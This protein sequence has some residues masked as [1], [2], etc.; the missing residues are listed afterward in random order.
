M[1]RHNGLVFNNVETCCDR[2][3]AVK[4]CDKSQNVIMTIIGVYMPSFQG[5]IINREI[6]IESL[7]ALQGVIDSVEGKYIIM[8]DLNVQ[9]PIQQKLTP[10]WYKCRP[11]TTH[12]KLVYD[13]ASDN[14]LTAATLSFPH[15][16]NFTWHRNEKKSF[17]DH[18]MASEEM[19]P[20]VT[21][22][23]VLEAHPDNVSD[24]LPVTCQVNVEMSIYGKTHQNSD[25]KHVKPRWA[26]SDF[27]TRYQRSLKD[28]L[29]NERITDIDSLS[30][31]EQAQVEITRIDKMVSGHML[32]ATQDGLR[33]AQTMGVRRN[34]LSRMWD[35][36]CQKAKERRDFWFH[37]FKEA[38][39]PT[40][41]QVYTCYKLAKCQFRA[42]CRNAVNNHKKDQITNLCASYN[43]HRSGVFWNKLKQ[44]TKGNEVHVQDIELKTLENHFK[45]KFEVSPF[46]MSDDGCQMKNENNEAYR[47]YT[48]NRDS[49]FIFTTSM[50]RQYVHKLNKSASSGINGIDANHLIYGLEAGLDVFLSVILTISLRFGVVPDSF[51]NGVLIPILKKPGLDPSLPGNYRPIIVSVVLSKILELH[52]NNTSDFTPADSMFGFTTGRGTEMGVCLTNDVC[53]YMLANG[54]NAYICSLDAQAAFDG[55]SHAVLFYHSRPYLE[56]ACWATLYNWYSNLHVSLVWNSS[57]SSPIIIKKGTRQG[58]LS[59]PMLFNI[60]YKPMVDKLNNSNCGISINNRQYNAFIYADDVLVTS[61]TPSGLQ[62]L[63]NIAA[64]EITKLGLQFNPNKTVCLPLGKCPYIEQPSWTLNGQSLSVVDQLTYLGV[65]I[66]NSQSKDH[67]SN[68]IRACNRSFYSLIPAGITSTNMPPAIK[69]ALWTTICRPTLLYGCATMSVNKGTL[70]ATETCQSK[71]MKQSLQISKLCH[72][73]KLLQAL[74]IQKIEKSLQLQ[75]LTLFSSIMCNTS[76]ATHFYLDIITD[77]GRYKQSLFHRTNDLMK[78]HNMNLYDVLYKSKSALK[79]KLCPRIN[80]C[81]I[82]DTIKTLLMNFNDFNRNMLNSL[83]FPI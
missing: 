8:G 18:I 21:T 33:G 7:D 15:M 17:I 45:N 13:F 48:S 71:L 38:G 12:S 23:S 11:F 65:T 9:L 3:Q 79:A 14:Q 83:L 68:R 58:G 57:F 26:D 19:M 16:P 56:H 77:A 27:V 73:S 61:S 41:G 74:D 64:E 49:T 62:T 22:C 72:S 82:T 2:I 36:T 1:K 28:M 30:N 4:I 75:T 34:R 78:Q 80:Q 10:N 31:P 32:K 69:A 53:Q 55:I 81:G 44:I 6:Y 50:V 67:F 59:S 43:R 70:Q 66:S 46:D 52:I 39:R 63:L 54:S 29:I 42:A 51:C 25:I 37:M 5:S 40:S 20:K 35:Q 76:A 60:V 47:R 24:H